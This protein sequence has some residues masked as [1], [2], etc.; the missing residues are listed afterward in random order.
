MGYSGNWLEIHAKYKGREPYLNFVEQGRC[1]WWRTN[2]P[3][4]RKQNKP[5]ERFKI[6]DSSNHEYY[7]S[8]GNVEGN[9]SHA[10]PAGV[11]KA[12]SLKLITA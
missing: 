1:K 2:L 9:F 4:K 7:K 3:F 12:E 8:Y 11:W 10:A 6:A 5:I